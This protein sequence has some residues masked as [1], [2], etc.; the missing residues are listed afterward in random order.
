LILPRAAAE[1]ALSLDPDLADAYPVLG[2]V[3]STFDWEW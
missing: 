1:K 2:H 3:S